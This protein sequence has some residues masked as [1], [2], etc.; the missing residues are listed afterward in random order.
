MLGSQ[1]VSAAPKWPKNILFVAILMIMNIRHVRRQE[2]E[3][4]KKKNKFR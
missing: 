1:L 2:N 4:K 3:K